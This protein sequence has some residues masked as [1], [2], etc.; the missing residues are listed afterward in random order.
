MIDG[1]EILRILYTQ[2]HI[3]D[4]DRLG[5]APASPAG[6]DVIAPGRKRLA[7]GQIG[8]NDKGQNQWTTNMTIVQPRAANI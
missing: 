7:P 4:P 6:R 8:Y 5:L 1:R 3:V 2:S